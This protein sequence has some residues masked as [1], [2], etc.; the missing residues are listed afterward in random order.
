MGDKNQKEIIIQ[1]EVNTISQFQC[2]VLKATNYTVW[3]IRIKTILKANGLWEMIEPSENTQPDEKKDMAATAYLFQA[4]PEDMI[5]QVASCKNAKEIWEALQTRHIG[6]DR[7]QKARLQT[8]KTEFEMLK[9]REDDSIDVFSAKLNS[10]VTRASGLGSTFD[11]QTLVRK[12]LSSVPKRFIQIVA[13][14]EQFSDLEKT[15][16]DEIIGR[17]KAFEERLNLLSGNPTDN[18]D[19]LL[20]T[21]HDNSSSH[22][23]HFKNGGQEKFRSSQNN[24][25]DERT[26]P[27]NKWKKSPHKFKKNNFQKGA[28]DLSKVKCYKCNKLGHVRRNCKLKDSGQEQ[29]NLVQEDIEPTLLMAVQDKGDKVEEI[30][31]DEKEIEPEKYISTD[32]SLWYLDNGASNHMTGIRTHFKEIDEKISG[33]VRFGDGSYVEIKGRGS[34]LLECKNKEQRIILNVYYIPSLKSNI[35]SLGQLTENGCKIIMQDNVLLLY[36]QDQKLLMRVERSRNRLYKINL[37]VGVPICLLTN[38][39]DHAWLWHARLGHLNFDSIKQMTRKKLVEG[40]PSI[41]HKNQVCNACLLGKHSRAPFPN[42]T[43]TKSLEPLNLV[44]GDLCGPISPATESGKKYM[45]LLVDDCTRYMWV[46]FLNSKDEAFE[47]FKEF[48]LK[49]ENEVEKKLKTLRTDRG[50]EFTSREFTR[51]CKENGIFRQLTAPY[52]PQ[53]NGIVERRNRSVM[54]TTR[55]M[56]KAMNMPQNFWAEAIRHAVYV[57]NR[58]PTK[59]LRDSTPYEALKGTKPNLRHLRVFG[60]KAYAKV[61]KPHLKKLDDRSKELVYLGTEPGSKA[62]RLFDPVTKG[63]I[64]S[65]DVKFKEDVGWDWNGYLDNVDPK[66]PEWKDFIINDNRTSS[67][68][69]INEV[70]TQDPESNNEVN[71]PS[72]MQNNAQGDM[73]DDEIVQPIDNLSTPPPYTYEPNSEESAGYTSSIA[74]SLRSYDHTPVQGFRNLSEIYDRAPEVQS[75]ELLLLEEEPRNYKEAV[76]DKK[77]IEAMQTEINAINKNKTWKLATLPDKQK[78]I[79]LK[80]V[81]K[82]KRDADGKIIKYKARLVAKGY[83]Q[84]HGIDYDE[85]FAPVARMET[86]R[87]IL[88]LAAYHGWEVHHLDVKSAFLHGEL[89]EEVYVTQPEGF[90]KPGNENKVYRLTK[91]LYGLKQAPRAWNMKLDQTLKSLDFKKCTLEQAVYTRISKDSMLLVGIYVDDLI[92]T[93]SSKEDLQKFKSQMEEKFEMSDLGLLAYYLGIEV[94]QTGGGISIKQSGYA[95]KILTKARMLDCNETK[96]PMDPG[97]KLIKTEGGELV[98]ATKYRSLIGCLRY[99]LHTRPDLSYSVGLLS[100]FMQEPKEQ[101]MKAIRQVLRYIKGT[102]NF[103]ITYKKKGGCK[104]LGY[105]DSSYGINTEEGKG[106]TGIVFYFGNSPISWNSQKQPTVALSSCE[107][108][109]MAATVAACQAL[110]LQR[111]LSALTGWKEE[112]V[113]IKVDNKSAIALMKNPVFHGRSKHIDTKYHF[114]R[115]CVEKNQIEVEHVSGDLQRA[116]ILTK[117]LARIKFADMRE[118]LGVK[119]LKEKERD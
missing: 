59:A 73:S 43:N 97:T 85:V 23:K 13:A 55:S 99:L 18:Q 34:I 45:F 66:E 84:E 87:L 54:C 89:K 29:S 114:I 36:G 32:E 101:H 90:I 65:R 46:Y 10:I 5:L 38:L 82:L 4:L 15:T 42:Q 35:L 70:S 102:L 93:G 33:R 26:K 47:T 44:F 107:S 91:A 81:F 17:L 41:S 88:A 60:C 48:K 12:L 1:K 68:R 98:D 79:G 16:L 105:S 78:A 118:L 58:V 77:W 14:I 52:S 63:I 108:E 113:T 94:T 27:F 75:N 22:E 74:S 112:K 100:R 76:R 3:A 106:T 72:P 116:D 115:E 61:T 39:E 117:A 57:L 110:W 7:V 9:M 49:V 119:N 71:T 2:P 19:K 64:V 24:K 56:L 111:L 62:Y 6:V 8:L 95:N 20:F 69:I 83:V 92:V 104:L 67:S 40:I 51:Y 21:N 103:G 80:W 25:Q 28:K 11:Q 109:F 37:K 31:L 50:G 30:F 96:I 86:I 53:Q